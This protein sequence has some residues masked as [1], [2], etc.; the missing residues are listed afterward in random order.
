MENNQWRTIFFIQII[1]RHSHNSRHY[2]NKTRSRLGWVF[3]H[4]FYVMFQMVFGKKNGNT[5]FQKYEL[6]DFQSAH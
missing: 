2:L 5:M 1:P 3:L 4:Q 6:L